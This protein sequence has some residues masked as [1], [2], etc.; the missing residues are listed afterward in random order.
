R[1]KPEGNAGDELRRRHLPLPVIGRRVAHIE[2]PGLYRIHGFE[3]RNYFASPKNFDL[4]PTIGEAANGFSQ[5]VRAGTQAGK[6]SWP[7]GLHAQPLNVLGDARG[8]ERRRGYEASCS[9][10]QSSSG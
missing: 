2:G 3:R 5:K 9:T 6:V 8:R 4:H 1:R 10:A 7:G